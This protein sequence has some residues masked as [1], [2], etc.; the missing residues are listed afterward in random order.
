MSKK[1][2]FAFST[3]FQI[4]IRIMVLMIRLMR[5]NTFPKLQH[6]IK[7]ASQYNYL[8][9]HQGSD[10]NQRTDSAFHFNVAR[11]VPVEVLE[12]TESCNHEQVEKTLLS[13]GI[14]NGYL[15]F[16]RKINANQYQR[17][18]NPDSGFGNVRIQETKT[19]KQNL[20]LRSIF[21]IMLLT[22]RESLS[23]NYHKYF[24]F[25]FS[26]NELLLPNIHNFAMD[27]S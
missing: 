6:P 7:D 16:I 27:S 14:M 20:F 3:F 23:S 21:S 26:H 15:A 1:W 24:F 8:Q 4:R 25:L 2:S 13:R 5:K 17:K 11:S 22:H 10:G 9:A 18:P 19:I 12:T